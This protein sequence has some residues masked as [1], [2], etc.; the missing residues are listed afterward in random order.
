MAAPMQ[1][2][3]IFGSESVQDE[4]QT[5]REAG[6]AMRLR[7]KL[8]ATAAALVGGCFGAGLM[9]GAAQV[10]TVKDPGVFPGLTYVCIATAGESCA[11]DELAVSNGGN[12]QGPEAVSN[13]GSATGGE[14]ALAV[15]GS[16]CAG[17]DA[18]GST[19]IA[20]GGSG[21]YTC[22]YWFETLAFGTQ[23]SSQACSQGALIWPSAWFSVAVNLT[24]SASVYC[25]WPDSW[26]GYG[27]AVAPMGSATL[28]G[29]GAAVSIVGPAS[30]SCGTAGAISG[31]NA[32]SGTNLAITGGQDSTDSA[33]ATDPN[34][35][36]IAGGKGNA[37]GGTV[38]V[39]MEGNA[40]AC[41]GAL[42]IAFV[43]GQIANQGGSA[44]VCNGSL[45]VPIP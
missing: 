15:N 6:I 19:A 9:P 20:V 35:V 29:M 1:S 44:S 24:G 42:T 2:G 18:G 23:G 14:L 30:A 21:A 5:R 16:A 41:G 34:S 27:A 45:P 38:A 7:K 28:C 11:S 17:D 26:G 13:G 22:P 43:P 3:F 32:A 40:R 12:A 25:S 39:S 33:T 4:D 37:N 10:I 8:G 36:A 31:T